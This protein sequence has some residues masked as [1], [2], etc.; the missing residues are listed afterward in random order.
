M[1]SV[2]RVGVAICAIVLGGAH[3][4]SADKIVLANDEWTTS[5]TGFAQANAGATNYVL[6][7]A[8]FFTG[9]GAGTFLIVSDNFSLDLD[10]ATNFAATLTGAGH[11]LVD[12]EDVAGF[13]FDLP[14]LQ[15]YDGVFFAL[16]PSIDQNVLI[17]YVNAGGNVYINGGTGIGG[18]P[19]E[20]ADWNT[21][22]NAFGLN[23]AAAYNGIGGVIPIASGHP[24]MAGVPSLYQN[25]GNTITLVGGN[26][27]AQIIATSAQGQ[28]LYAVYD[29]TAIPEPGILALF[30]IGVL[31]AAARRRTR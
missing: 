16:P 13:A 20:A 5:N 29:A 24:V 27:N 12:S 21:F 10:Q 1:R 25:N 14:T 26:P 6:N 9:G 28:G 7:V 3:I 19:S 31:A 2:L 8:E 17:N 18:A 30:G 4:A 15:N 22:L 23:F 11:T